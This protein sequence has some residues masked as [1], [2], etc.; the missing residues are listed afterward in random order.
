MPLTPGSPEWAAKLDDESR[1]PP[2][3]WYLSF[4]TPAGFLGGAFILAPGA[5]HAH[6]VANSLGINPGGQIM[7][8]PVP[9]DRARDIPKK[10]LF[11]LLTKAELNEL[12]YFSPPN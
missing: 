6:L 10:Y 1:Q 5:A 2:R 7:F 8:V 3:W 11:R 4:G 9:A 12:D